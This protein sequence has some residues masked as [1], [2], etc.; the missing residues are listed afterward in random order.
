MGLH[1]CS[2]EYV[3][4]LGAERSTAVSRVNR[5]TAAV[6]AVN[7]ENDDVSTHDG[8]C[9]ADLRAFKFEFWAFAFV[10]F[11]GMFLLI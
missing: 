8:S 3:H 4:T 10:I 1:L 5:E 7:R 6:I 9:I 2:G 11:S